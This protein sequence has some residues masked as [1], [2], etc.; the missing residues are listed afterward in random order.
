MERQEQERKDTQ[1]RKLEDRMKRL[2][3]QSRKPRKVRYKSNGF[4]DHAV[5]ANFS[6]GS[7]S[8]PRSLSNLN[9]VRKAQPNSSAL[10]QSGSSPTAHGLVRRRVRSQTGTSAA[11]SKSSCFICHSPDHYMASCP[12]AICSICRQRGHTRRRCTVAENVIP[13]GACFNCGKLGHR[14]QE[15][16]QLGRYGAAE[17]REA[18]TGRRFLSD[19]ATTRM[20]SCEE[21]TTGNLMHWQMACLDSD[22][23]FILD[24]G[25][26]FMLLPTRYLRRARTVQTER[27]SVAP[28][29]AERRQ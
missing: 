29:A 13:W 6:V 18:V 9:Y 15:C 12:K 1:I 26:N 8:N 21:S 7:Y 4:G 19:V 2:E 11:F 25:G 16:H 3:A 23:D 20:F 10:A 28:K 17:N 5:V 27:T 14:R 22:P 24:S